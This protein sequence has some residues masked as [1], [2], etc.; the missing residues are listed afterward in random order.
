MFQRCAAGGRQIHGEARDFGHAA[1]ADAVAQPGDG[2]LVAFIQQG[3]N[4]GQRLVHDRHGQRIA[5]HRIDRQLQPQRL[6]QKGEKLP[7]AT[8]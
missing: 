8:R 4:G 7:S 3:G 6:D 1:N 2:H 5:L